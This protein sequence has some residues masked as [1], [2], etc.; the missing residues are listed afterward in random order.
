METAPDNV[1]RILIALGVIFLAALAFDAIGRRTPLPRVTMLLLFGFAVGPSGLDVLPELSKAWFPVVSD[2]ALVMI[3]F[4]LGGRL[5]R[6]NLRERGRLVVVL[7][8]AV[9]AATV[10]VLWLGLLALGVP[11]A[12]ALLLAAIATATDPAA[13]ADV[14][15]THG[16]ETPFTDTLLAAVTVDDVWGLVVFSLALALVLLAQGDG[17]SGVLFHGLWDLGGALAL[18]VAL[19]VPMARLTGRID[20]GEPSLYEALGLV[21]LCGGLA[22]WLDVSFLLASMTLGA[23]VANL[24]SHHDRPFHAIE[25]IE[26]PFL[27]V[28]FVLAG[29]ALD[30]GA[31]AEAGPWLI[32]YVVLRVVGRLLGGWLG[33]ALLRV[34]T[35]MPELRQMGLAM[36]PQ[37]GVALG[38]ALVAARNFPDQGGAILPVVIAATVVFEVIGPLATRWAIA[39]ADVSAA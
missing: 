12:V 16:R 6:G 8:L 36:L 13:T 5:T 11:G 29:A 1:A 17:A 30:L 3:G 38:M 19:G 7:S 25:G 27:I 34:G 28:F 9:V 39:R 32:A 10:A 33:V 37:A 15:H 14:V 31:L 2:M 4:L 21:F 22:L 20:P 24:A 35:G 23:V 18:G 26:W